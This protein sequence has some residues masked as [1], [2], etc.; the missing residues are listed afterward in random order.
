MLFVFA[1]TEFSIVPAL[2]CQFRPF[3]QEGWVVYQAH[4]VHFVS[5]AKSTVAARFC[6]W[7]DIFQYLPFQCRFC[8]QISV[9]YMVGKWC[10]VFV[11][12]TTEVR[13][14]V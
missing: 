1:K 11:C 9:S 10:W 4:N 13:C 14:E 3:V 6:I 2:M 7:I 5:K 12:F 8:A